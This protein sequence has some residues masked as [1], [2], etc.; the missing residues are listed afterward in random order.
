MQPRLTKILRDGI[1]IAGLDNLFHSTNF[2]ERQ[3]V[4]PPLRLFLTEFT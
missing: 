3:I 1:S 4:F 2:L